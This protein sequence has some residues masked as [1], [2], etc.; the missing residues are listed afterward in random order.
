MAHSTV[1]ASGPQARGS[2]QQAAREL[3]RQTVLH[4]TRELLSERDWSEVTM[5]DIATAAGMSRQTLYNEFKSRHGVAEAYA[6]RLV[7]SYVDLFGAA[8]T[9][10]PGDVQGGLEKGFADFLIEAATDPLVQSALAGTAK[11]DVMRLVTTDGGVIL[12]AASVR[13]AKIAMDAWGL[14]DYAAA[15]RIGR[16]VVRQ[17]MSFIT[18]APRPEENPAADLSR[19]LAPLIESLR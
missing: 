12:D 18:L 6:L 2:Y 11:L 1:S 17:A 14:Q 19:V 7:D 10:H 4:A 15:A 3:L 8:V 5:A 16:L 9:G 13:L